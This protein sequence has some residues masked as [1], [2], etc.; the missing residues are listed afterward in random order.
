MSGY[1][2]K[3]RELAW[4]ASS[5]YLATGGSAIVIVWDCSGKGPSGTKP[6]ELDGHDLPLTALAYQPNGRFLI[7]GC[8]GGK[9]VLW[10]PAKARKP[11][12]RSELRGEITGLRWAP[13]SRNLAASSS[14]G[15][16]RVFRPAAD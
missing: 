9:I 3:V 4:D 15:T 13:D 7:S 6:I 5:R 14:T 12:R 8:R 10:N 1:P 2:V 16:V 11:I